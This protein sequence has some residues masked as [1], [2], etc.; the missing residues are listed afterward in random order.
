VD[1]TKF[2]KT[3]QDY[4]LVGESKTGKR[5]AIIIVSTHVDDGSAIRYVGC[6]DG[7]GKNWMAEMEEDLVRLLGI[8]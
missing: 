5:A 8:R 2:R 7:S 1:F 3:N 6:K 4:Q